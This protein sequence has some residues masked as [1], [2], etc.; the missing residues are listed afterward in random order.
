MTLKQIAALG[1]ELV[2]FLAFF[3][4]CFGR[5]EPRKL[6]EVY[7]RGQLSE[8]DR[9]S[10]EPMAIRAGIPPRTLQRFVESIKWNEQ[11]LRDRCQEMVAT[12]HAHPRAIGI[13]DEAQST[14][15]VLGHNFPGSEWYLDSYS[16]LTGEDLRPESSDSSWISRIWNSII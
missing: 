3:R 2:R 7:V 1:S 10:I 15:A 16:M 6:L 11:K 4:D 5:H 8:L 9:K 14:A 13:V 12:Q